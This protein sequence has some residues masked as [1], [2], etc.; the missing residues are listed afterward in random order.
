MFRRAGRPLD[1]EPQFSS[2]GL[3][4]GRSLAL[5]IQGACLEGNLQRWI[6][7]SS[8]EEFVITWDSRMGRSLPQKPVSVNLF[9]L[10]AE[11]A[12]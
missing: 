10:R 4:R 12:P 1:N 7:A 2:R 9:R 5:T 11:V 3:F 8:A 6:D